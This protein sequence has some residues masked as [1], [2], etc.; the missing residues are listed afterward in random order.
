MSTILERFKVHNFRSI[1]KS[2]WIELADNSCLVGTNEAGKTNLLIA[3]WKLRPANNEPI[4]PLDDFP[5]HLFSRYDTDGHSQDVFIT[6]DFILDEDLQDE[7]SDELNCDKEQ[8]R[9]VLVERKYDG[10]YFISFPYSK[11]DEFDSSRAIELLSEFEEILKADDAFQ[12]ED[13]NLQKSILEFISKNKEVFEKVDS[14]KKDDIEKLILDI[15]QFKSDNF[16]RKK[17][18]PEI[19]DENLISQLNFFTKAFNGTPIE[20]TSEIRQKVLMSL[21]KFVYYSDYGNLDSEIF[22]P[23]VIEDFE[24]TDLTE[25]ARA[26]ARTL[27]VLF[28]YVGLS[29]EEIYELGNDRKVIIKKMDNHGREIST[30]EQDLSDEEIR[31][32]ADKK[33]KRGILLTSAATELTKS[34]K[35]WWLQGDYI[36]AF[37]ADGHHFRINVSDSLRPEPIELEGR[38]RGLQWFFSFFLVFLVETKEAHSNTILLLDEPGLSLHPIAQYDLAKFFRK[39]SLDNQLIYTSHS[40]FLVDME[41]LANVK[42]VYIDKQS[43]RTK[44]SSNLRYDEVDAEK[45]IYPVHAALG[46]TVSDTLLL[47]CLPVL[48]E[49][50]SD[51][52]YLNLIK[53]YL[54]GKGKLKYSKEFV[55]IPTGGVR[56]MGPVSKLVSSRE[57][58]LPFVLVDSDKAG[59][60]YKKQLT[61]ERYRDAKEK[62]LEVADFLGN[63][64]FEIEDLIPSDAM[65]R[66]IDRMFRANQ[67]FEDVFD[68]KK[69]IIDQIEEWAKNNSIELQDGWKV[70][71]SRNIQNRFEKLFENV[72]NDLLEA[73]DKLFQI[74]LK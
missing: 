61:K 22:L 53:R 28:K 2:D 52:I 58:E 11:I 29:P 4:V 38:S 24:R 14:F 70:D 49:G 26:K 59:K 3:L 30:E 64:D 40:P 51:Q 71:L 39:L 66:T 18:L 72:D 32:W 48:V 55:F 57:N 20:T 62:V 35:N 42:A 74:M 7:L 37:L 33:R 15:E 13:E 54:I 9:K 17:N 12:K 34:F 65:V 47:G 21:P 1:E 27:K 67:F 63:Q 73:W 69:P 56:G 68:A 6:A 41:N 16:G 45:S 46:L 31:D 25:S 50:V 36:F 43:G 23:R 8:I 60:E 44:V 5:R 10:K 19:F